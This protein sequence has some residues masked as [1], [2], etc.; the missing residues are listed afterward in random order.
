ML[1][2]NDIKLIFPS[3]HGNLISSSELI[4]EGQSPVHLFIVQHIMIFGPSTGGPGTSKTNV[5]GRGGSVNRLSCTE[6]RRVIGT[7][8]EAVDITGAPN[9]AGFLY[10][11]NIRLERVSETLEKNQNEFKP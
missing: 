11:N 6:C 8:V 1:I 4:F 10:R 3:S 7:S 5:P 9:N 2:M